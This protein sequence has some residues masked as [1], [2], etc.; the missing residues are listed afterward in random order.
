MKF[1]NKN[2]SLFWKIFTNADADVAELMIKEMFTLELFRIPMD[3]EIVEKIIRIMEDS[4]PQIVHLREICRFF[5]I[6]AELYISP[7]LWDVYPNYF[8]TEYLNGYE[9]WYYMIKKLGISEFF[10]CLNAD[11]FPTNTIAFSEMTMDH[12]IK[13]LLPLTS[14]NRKEI[15]SIMQKALRKLKK[16]RRKEKCPLCRKKFTKHGIVSFLSSFFTEIGIVPFVQDK[17]PNKDCQYISSYT[18]NFIINYATKD[19]AVYFEVGANKNL[20]DAIIK[21]L[22]QMRKEG[23]FHSIQLFR[24]LKFPDTI[25][26]KFPEDV[27]ECE[28][29][30]KETRASQ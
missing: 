9:L 1:Y 13:E 10:M 7:E 11:L 5:T 14:L 30:R 22:Y 8:E 3:E 4:Y 17:F 18:V 25:R 16:Y 27:Y 29:F 19:C 20:F 23:L 2:E 24:P 15:L 26:K 28:P 6:A 21:K 12:V